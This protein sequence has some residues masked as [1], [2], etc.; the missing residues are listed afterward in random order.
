MQEMPETWVG[1]S[2][3]RR[4]WQPTPV[5]LPGK[6]HR[7][8]NVAGYSSRGLKESGRTE[9]THKKSLPNRWGFL[10]WRLPMCSP[11]TL[12]VLIAYPT[13]ELTLT[14]GALGNRR[15][16][17]LPYSYTLSFLI[18]LCSHYLLP[19]SSVVWF[20]III[21]MVVWVN[22]AHLSS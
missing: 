1:K 14:R 16:S 12:S 20:I 7:Q 19:L 13:A 17:A 8:R 10:G 11:Q 6:S 21:F 9:H 18:R 3:W 22:K 4:K 15:V 2:P 5:S